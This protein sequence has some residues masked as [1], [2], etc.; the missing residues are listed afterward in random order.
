MEIIKPL[1]FA[2]YSLIF[3]GFPSYIGYSPMS[4]I[5][6]DTTRS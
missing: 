3:H 5:V 1:V 2:K 6:I 4:L